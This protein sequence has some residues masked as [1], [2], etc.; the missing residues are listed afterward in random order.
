M[1]EKLPTGLQK[2]L[3]KEQYKDKKFKRRYIESRRRGQRN[4][5]YENS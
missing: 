3:V 1:I 4:E 5:I 2:Y